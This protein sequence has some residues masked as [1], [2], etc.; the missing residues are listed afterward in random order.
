M[1]ET[2]TETVRAEITKAL[3]EMAPDR[4]ADNT[5]VDGNQDL[6]EYVDS[7]GFVQL[8]MAIEGPLGVELDLTTVDLGSIVRFDDLTAFVLGNDG[9]PS[10]R[11]GVNV[12]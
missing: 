11:N 10:S 7:F 5:V 6:L 8:L 9:G 2:R 4:L 12:G 3:A 1:S